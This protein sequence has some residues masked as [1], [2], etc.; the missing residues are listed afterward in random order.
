[1]QHLTL[2]I[3]IG[4]LRAHDGNDN[5]HISP[6]GDSLYV[7]KLRGIQ[8][9]LHEKNLSVNTEDEIPVAVP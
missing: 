5:R 8:F 4:I 3:D 9:L 2:V 6:T 7:L 1:M